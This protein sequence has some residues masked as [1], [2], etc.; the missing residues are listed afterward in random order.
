MYIPKHF[1]V[2]DVEVMLDLIRDYP[3]ASLVAHST[4]GLNANHIALHL[5]DKPTPFGVLQG[6]V[7]RSNPLLDDISEEVEILTDQN[8]APF[9]EPLAVAD[10]PSDFTDKLL[11]SIIGIEMKITKL[12]G[13]WKVSQN[14]PHE[15]HESV[16]AGLKVTK[17]LGAEKMAEFVKLAPK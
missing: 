17:Q 15:N 1:E 4:K 16:I 7:L 13:K 5:E 9:S 2:T 12:L 10:A 14:Q 3:L 11:P 8:G 6:H